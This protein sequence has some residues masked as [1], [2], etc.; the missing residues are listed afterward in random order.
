[1]AQSKKI[2][3]AYETVGKLSNFYDGMITNS[4]FL[5]RLAMKIFWGLS[6][7]DYQKFLNQAFAGVPKNFAGRLLEVPVGTGVISLPRF[8]KLHDAEIFCVDYSATMLNAAEKFSQKLNLPKV[9]FLKGDVGN[10]PFEDENFDLVISVDGL[11]AFPDKAAA[12]HEMWRVLKYGGI[13]CGSLYVKGQNWR[14][15]LFVKNFCVW[16]GFFTPPFET[17]QTLSEKL[18]EL[19]REVQISN[20]QSFAGFICK[21]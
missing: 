20:V 5:G 16:L 2:E 18:G 8:E 12:Y 17:L 3:A 9:K 4:S 13:F 1:M 6:D 15:D 19:Y 10:L 14:T 7:E 11:H 21:K